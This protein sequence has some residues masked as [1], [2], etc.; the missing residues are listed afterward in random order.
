MN[1]GEM[2]RGQLLALEYAE[3]SKI[4]RSLLERIPADKWNW[5]PHEK[6]WSMGNLGS[7]LVDIFSWVKPTLDLDELVLN[8]GEFTPF[9]AEDKDELLATFDTNLGEALDAIRETTE[10]Q[11]MAIWRM[12][13]NGQLIFEM[14]RAAVIR[15]MIIN[16]TIHHRA[17]L[18]IY[19]RLNDVPVP[20]SYGPTADEMF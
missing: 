2:T 11:L 20:K 4:T 7:H 18:G 14:P 15:I 13:S 8:P 6:S 10:E 19:L 1:V 16:H 3:E 12:K 17:Q 9:V 5:K